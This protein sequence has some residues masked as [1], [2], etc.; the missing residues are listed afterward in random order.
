METGGL[1]EESMEEV[2]VEVLCFPTLTLDEVGVPRML[3]EPFPL[4][5]PFCLVV[6]T[7]PLCF[8]EV[9]SSFLVSSGDC[10]WM[11]GLEGVVEAAWSVVGEQGL[12]PARTGWPLTL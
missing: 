10:V 12:G 6:C 2:E 9:F 7:K 4:D 5:R 1:V 8:L 11:H 3:E